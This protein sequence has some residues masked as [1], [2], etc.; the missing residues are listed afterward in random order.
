MTTKQRQGWETPDSPVW[1]VA[2][3]ALCTIA[4]SRTNLN[5]WKDTRQEDWKEHTKVMI[6][7]FHYSNLT[8]SL[9]LGVF[10]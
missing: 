7:R 9:I 4:V 1:A 5:H 2:F 3:R 8:V 6:N 10:Q